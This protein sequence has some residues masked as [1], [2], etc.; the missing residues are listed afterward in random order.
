MKTI[1][2]NNCKIYFVGTAHVS[3][4]SIEEVEKVISEILP[5]GIAVEL[6]ERRFLTIMSENKNKKIDIKEALKS[7][8][9]T[10][11]LIYIFLSNSQKKIG[12]MFGVKP[13]SEMK[14]AIELSYLYNIPIY[15]IDRDINITL[16]RLL[17][18]MPLKEKIKFLMALFE[19]DDDIE[20]N[21]EKLREILNNPKKYVE[22][23]KKLSPTIYNVLVDERDKYMAK[24]IFE[25]SKIKNSL[26][27]VVGAGHVDGIINY[28]KRL[29]NGEKIDID[30]LIKV[31]DKKFKFSKIFGYLLTI[32]IFAFLG[33]ILYYSISNPDI[34]KLLTI[35]WIIFTGGLAA[36]GVVLAR[37]KPLTALIAFLSA[38][39]TTLI[40]LPFAA[41][42]TVAGLVELKFREITDKDIVNLFEADLKDLLNNNLFRILLVATLSN[43]GATIGVF[44]CLGKFTHIFILFPTLFLTIQTFL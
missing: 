2:I 9:F 16:S 23:L 38:P 33:Y 36:L 14:K 34:L 29:E 41:V 3:K 17:E 44:Y 5:E 35:N 42:G 21:E 13:G 40:P 22:M 37:G 30:E 39:I 24:K 43:L 27:V 26:V 12:E 4:D 31:K 7:G 8:D 6:D 19:E 20:I 25:L 11:L 32:A 10:K 1:E 18:K 28:L 15:L